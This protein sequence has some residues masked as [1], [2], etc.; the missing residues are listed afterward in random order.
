MIFAILFLIFV[1]VIFLW[2]ASL[3]V[4][5]IGG[6]PTVYAKTKAIHLAFES[7]ELK[8][9]QT[10]VDLGCG[11][12]RSL[13]IASKQ[14]GAKGIGIEI[15]PFY[16]LLAKASVCFARESENIKII[17][18]DL[19][20][21]ERYLKDA[22]VIYMYLFNKIANEIEAR[23]FETTKP[24]TKIISLAFPLKNHQGILIR[25]NPSIYIYKK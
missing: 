19:R 9:G 16:Y 25:S 10:V 20:K 13:I 11:N 24:G 2:Q 4:A 5:V 6:A 17:F 12:A 1:L 14:F 23:I 7:V 15:S 18:G 3:V 21:K 22:D 8:Q